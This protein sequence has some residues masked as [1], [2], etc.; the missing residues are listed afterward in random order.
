MKGKTRSGSVIILIALLITFILYYG[1]E[2]FYKPRPITAKEY[3]KLLGIGINVDWMSFNKTNYYY[4]YWRNKGVN[5][6]VLFREEGF[7]NVRIRV[8]VDVINNSKAL[9]ELKDIVNDCLKAGIIPI[10]TYTAYDIRNNPTNPQAVKHFIN[11]WV[12]IA[13]YFKGTS[14]LLSYDLVIESSGKIKNYPWLLD[15]IYNETITAIRK[16]DRYRIIIVTAPANISSPFALK[17][18]KIR[19]D[20]YIIAEWHIYA[21]GPCP[22]RGE[23]SSGPVYSREYIK[24]AVEVAINWSKK[25]DIPI[26]M[27]AW[28]PNCYPK[29]VERYYPD[30]APKGLYTVN[31]VLP[32]VKYMTNI[33]CKNHIP[34]DINADTRFFDIKDLRWYG[35]Q[36]KILEVILSC[37]Q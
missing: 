7:S 13:R 33:L 20:P 30:G 29:H 11:W 16:I 31:Q 14:Y 26:W 37:K 28:R 34:F 6:P 17:Y 21:G 25:T 22:K 32:F 12:T 23:N 9:S 2:T 19:W 8:G 3:V 1:I 10:I 24:E 15:K 27:G 4:F 35:S 36:E 5:I 18:L